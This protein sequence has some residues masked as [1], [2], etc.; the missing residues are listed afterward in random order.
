MMIEHVSAYLDQAWLADVVIRAES[1]DDGWGKIG[2]ILF[3]AGPLFFAMKYFKYRNTDKRHRHESETK[4][5]MD[6]V[7]AGDEFVKS[8]KGLKNSRMPNANHTAVR[9]ARNGAKGIMGNFRIPGM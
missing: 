4:A 7:M 3:L 9:G 1:D 6:N 8:M 5:Q 2:L